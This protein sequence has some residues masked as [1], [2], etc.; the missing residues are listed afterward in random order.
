MRLPKELVSQMTLDSLRRV[1]GGGWKRREEMA[2]PMVFCLFYDVRSVFFFFSME[3]ARWGVVAVNTFSLTQYI[4]YNE[5]NAAGC[6]R[7]C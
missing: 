6:R 4:Y 1:G 7:C 3:L 2:S 5:I